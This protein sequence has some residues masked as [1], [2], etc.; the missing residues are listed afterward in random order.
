MSKGFNQQFFIDNRKTILSKSKCDLVIV[1]ANTA[2]Q[3]NGDSPYLFRQDSNFWYLCGVAKPDFVLVITKNESFLIAPRLTATQVIFDPHESGDDLKK[4]SGVSAIYE[5]V[6]GWLKLRSHLD[7]SQRV[8]MTSALNIKSWGITPNPSQEKLIKKIKRISKT[9]VINILKPL[10]HMRMIKQPQ[11]VRAIA[12]A[13]DITTD[14]LKQVA[15]GIEIQKYQNEYEIEA[16]LSYNFRKSGAQG[17][18]FSPVIAGGFNSTIPHYQSNNAS[19]KPGSVVVMDVGA[20]VNNYAAD[21]TRTI[22]YGKS[23]KRQ[24]QV[25]ESVARVQQKAILRLKPGVTLHESELLVEQDTGVELKKLGL[26]S[27]V[28]RKNIRRFYGHAASHMIGLDPHDLA[29]YSMPLAK[30]MVLTVEPGIYIPE[31]NIGVRIEDDILI[32][33]NGYEI[34]SKNLPVSLS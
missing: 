25:I 17:H 21:I 16:E 10:A 22:V 33:E 3:R 27:K 26:I 9:E 24:Q 31:E 34:L 6:K 2:V 29:D 1:S 7:D 32:T 18:A 12:R 30:N 8:G 5:N 15:A 13:I 28:N 19:L 4:A 14:S 23:T 20:E 11:E